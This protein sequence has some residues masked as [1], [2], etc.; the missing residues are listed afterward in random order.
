MGSIHILTNLNQ[1]MT[2]RVF[3]MKLN[4]GIIAQALPAAPQYICAGSDY[5]LTLAD[6]RALIPDNGL[7]ADDIL[8]LAVWNDLLQYESNLPTNICCIGGG[9]DALAFFKR[10]NLV[11]F[12]VEKQNPFIL[13]GIIQSIF[14]HYNN[15]ERALLETMMLREPTRT[16]LNCCSDFFQNH[17]IL[18]DSELNI[19]EYS[20]NYLPDDDDLTWKETLESGKRSETAFQ[21]A[22]KKTLLS[23][24]STNTNSEL[25]NLGGDYQQH[26]IKSFYDSNRRIATLTIAENNKPLFPCQEKLLDFI[27]N[28][29]SPN[30]FFRYSTLHGSLDILR[31]VFVTILNKV[32]VDPYVVSKSLAL[33]GWEMKDDYRLLLILIPDIS[34]A[35]E[36]M[37]QYL[38]QYENIFPDC[39]GFKFIEN[40]VLVVHNDT[41]DIIH[42]SIP[43]L[44]KLLKLNN[45]VCGISM[46]FNS[47]L[48]LN[49]QYKNADTAIQHGDK[50]ECIRNFRDILTYNLID[51]ISTVTPLIPLC[52]RD[53]LRIFDY[54]NENGTNLLLTMEIYLKHNKS[55]KHAAEEL[56]IHR[57]T[58]TYRLS[59]INKIVQMDLEDANER[60]H[61][62]LSCIVLR[63]LNTGSP[64][65]QP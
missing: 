63:N 27:S 58:L 64:R 48:Q 6:V 9:E 39:V 20:T 22:K 62:L 51:T 55:L 52:N 16:L 65:I 57:S 59:N 49:S 41:N 33:A 2:A 46:P 8:Y 42:E 47:I 15:L 37:T 13:Y 38:Y 1:E 19:I 5:N 40:L 24:P 50:S 12:I 10:N 32:S 54:D 28:I 23:D 56:Y 26:I 31:S 60:L 3:N 18:F 45:A 21:A 29:I 11:G 43:K 53:A 44:T 61:I 34:K 36:S 4:T 17:A 7:F 30:L 35:P 25:V 14:L